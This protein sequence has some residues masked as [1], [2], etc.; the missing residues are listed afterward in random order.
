MN[1]VQLV[2]VAKGFMKLGWAVQEQVE[3]VMEGRAEDC[4]PNALEMIRDWLEAAR[5]EAEGDEELYESLFEAVEEITG[6]LRRM[7]RDVSEP[8]RAKDCA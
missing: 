2:E 8:V 5:R 1:V 3:Q 7:G 4:N 6:A